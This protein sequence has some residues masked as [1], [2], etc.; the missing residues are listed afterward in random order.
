VALSDHIISSARAVGRTVLPPTVDRASGPGRRRQQGARLQATGGSLSAGGLSSPRSREQRRSLAASTPR[1]GLTAGRR[2]AVALYAAAIFLSAFLLFQVELIMGRLILPWFGGSAAVWTVTVLFF[3]VVLVLGYLYAHLL[4]S[5]VPSRRQMLVHVPVLLATLLVLPILPNPIWKPVGGQD[6]TLRILGLLAVTVGLPFFALSTTGPLLQA[7]YARG[8]GRPYRFYALSNA[9]S[10]LG[11]L[12]YPVLVEPHLRTHVQADAWS[13]AYALFVALG[14]GIAVRASISAAEVPTPARAIAATTQRPSR[15]AHLLWLA[16]AAVPSL[17][18][19]AVTNQL[20]QNIAPIP[21]L[22]VL[23][24]GIYL[25]SLIICFEGSG[26]YRRRLFLPLLPLALGLMAYNLFPQ[27]LEV[28]IAGQIAF[29]SAGLLV[30]CM[31]CHGELARLKPPAIH[32]TSFYLLVAV[33]GALGGLFVAVVAP[34]LFSGYF[35]LAL[36]LV[37]CALVVLVV[38]APGWL[39]RSPGRV[40][41]G[42]AAAA[43]ATTL[44]ILLSVYVYGKVRDHNSGDRVAVRNFYGALTVRDAG[45]PGPFALRELYS[46]TILHGEQFLAPQRARQ[47]TSYYG[48][49]SGVG[50]ALR[51]EGLTNKRLRVGVIGLGAGTIATYG[52]P[53]DWYQFYEI[54]PL[55]IQIAKTQFSFLRESPAHVD[56]VGGDARLSLER[57]P[58][59]RFNVLAVDAFSGD[60]V[61]IHLLTLQAFQLFF[62]HLAPNGVVAVHVSNRYLNLVPVVA[63]AAST[64]GKMAVLIDSDRNERGGPIKRAQWVLITGDRALAANLAQIGQGSFL[65]DHNGT[66]LWTDDYSDVIGALK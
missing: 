29:F 53:G 10:M 47:P 19:L 66:R 36:G 32:L 28:G 65:N 8:A 61:P 7:W 22:W 43:A 27:E 34:Q 24:L 57:E 12:S 38:L 3:Q 15:R 6:P 64:L 60:S 26:G 14:I 63:R 58:D 30:C 42:R 51:A 44:T 2:G 56:V 16:L 20:T 25:L 39:K 11:L 21:F 55:V 50:V 49:A 54:N 1:I 13:A 18:F 9:A 17:M 45:V 23:P 35:E 46:G 4:V 48:P 62:R 59:Q 33:G 5:H 37:L 31:V 40:W 52:R 41:A